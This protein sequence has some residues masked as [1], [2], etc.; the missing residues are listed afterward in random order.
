[1][2]GLKINELDFSK[3]QVREAGVRASGH[4][5]PGQETARELNRQAAQEAFANKEKC[6]QMRAFHGDN[7]LMAQ[8]I[9]NWNQ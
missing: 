3:D 6:P 7:A 8:R 1:M 5:K 2:S 9:K 4:S